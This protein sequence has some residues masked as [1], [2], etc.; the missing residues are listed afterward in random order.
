MGFVLFGIFAVMELGLLIWTLKKQG[1]KG[2]WLR[3]STAV[4]AVETAVF[5]LVVLLSEGGISFRFKI[6]LLV[7][8]LRLAVSLVFWLLKR[9]KA[10][11][12]KSKSGAAVST[13]MGI[14]VLGISLMPAFLFTGYA[15]LPTT[16]EYEV[17][18]ASAILVDESRIETFESDGSFREVPVYFYYP[19]TENTGAEQFPLVLFSHGAFGYYQSN[20]STYME[21]ASHG[22]VVV[23]MDHPYHSFFTKDSDGKLITVNPEFLNEV[24]RVDSDEAAPEE[25]M[26]LSH[27]W[28]DIRTADMGFVLDSL[29]DGAVPSD[30][31]TILAN[32][33]PEQIGLM[34]H[35]LGG[36]ASVQLGR[37][38]EDIDAVIDIDGTMLGEQLAF[39][40]GAYKYNEAPYPVPVL[41]LDNEKHHQVN[42]EQQAAYANWYVMEHAKDGMET[43]IAGSEHMNFTDLPLFSPI[44]AAKLGTGSR[45]AREC[46]EIMNEVVL[47]YFDH[48]LQGKDA[49]NIKE[50]Y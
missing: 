41:A 37:D 40:N 32:A 17:K 18:Q 38:R 8:F 24:M 10:L 28:L 16:G 3:N 14:L 42:L 25:V 27:K 45:D 33:D 23:S 7:L 22:Y 31:C 36:A 44:L 39:E 11:G 19:D 9:K 30:V 46:V 1:R 4:R 26:E 50:S 12:P 47:Q 20:T 49:L 34:G 13:C 5:L 35:S 43:W 6:C 21:L 29:E 48:Y 2:D 15:G